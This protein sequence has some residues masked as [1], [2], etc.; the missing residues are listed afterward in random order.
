[1]KFTKFQA[2]TKIWLF[3]LI[4]L[5]SYNSIVKS[6]SLRN[7]MKQ[8]ITSNLPSINRVS[9][10]ITNNKSNSS[11]QS[12]VRFSQ[13]GIILN[14]Y[15]D[16]N[17]DEKL[18]NLV[19]QKSD[20]DSHILDYRVLRD[21]N[22]KES[23][24]KKE[25]SIELQPK[26]LENRAQ[27]S[28]YKMTISISRDFEEFKRLFSLKNIPIDYNDSI[29][30]KLKEL[31]NRDCLKRKNHISE[32][33][34]RYS[35]D[36]QSYQEKKK[37]LQD[38]I[39][40]VK[41]KESELSAI[42]SSMTDTSSQISDIENLEQSYN[43]QLSSIQ[44]LKEGTRKL[45]QAEQ[46]KIKTLITQEKDITE[47][48]F[49]TAEDLKNKNEELNELKKNFDNL[50]E[51]NKKVE[52]AIIS[53]QNRLSETENK[54]SEVNSNILK[55]NYEIDNKNKENESNNKQ[56]DKYETEIQR[57][58]A[59]EANT[60]KKT[61]EITDEKNKLETDISNTKDEIQNIE[62]KINDL[63]KSK[64]MKQE[65][66]KNLY[67]TNKLKE[68]EISR[69]SVE[70]ERININKNETTQKK[71]HL[72]D[73]LSKQISKK[74]TKLTKIKLLLDKEKE[75]LVSKTT[76]IKEKISNHKKVHTKL[77]ERIDLNKGIINKNEK[78]V[79]GLVK[80]KGDIENAKN[81]IINKR[82]DRESKLVNL[83]NEDI[84]FESEIENVSKSLRSSKENFRTYN[85][86]HQE[87]KEKVD[88][89]EKT[90]KDLISSKKIVENDLKNLVKSIKEY[91][92]K[93][94]EETPS[95]V[96]MVD[97]AE[98][99]AFSSAGDKWKDLINRIIY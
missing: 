49:K 80:E 10:L 89:I 38:I 79:Y 11:F 53:Y 86:L 64:S 97:M 22:G 28:D 72:E 84:D 12:K 56:I 42:K 75:F 98:D 88:P 73:F 36:I 94:K 66:L 20:D 67:D 16:E 19:T 13:N 74:I 95:A 27:N 57:L 50:M 37:I 35:S 77:S 18:L 6:T 14:P 71:I 96:I 87:F 92:K 32:L 85:T 70:Q 91:S 90:Y 40:K 81:E 25:I 24:N 26:S 63:I 62:E 17:L 83:R 61:E 45:V 60:K 52:N 54:L 5:I 47:K 76:S 9:I 99:D 93:I 2:N 44:K 7:K 78:L 65:K 59:E 30:A 41:I 29:S 68:E 15:L 69:L 3:Y 31:V 48:E 46:M 1:M 43:R 33:K 21:C 51:E 8:E 82:R 4:L 55:N 39:N 34:D 58:I 23:E